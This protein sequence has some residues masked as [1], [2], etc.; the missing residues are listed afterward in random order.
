[1]CN[2]THCKYIGSYNYSY[3]CYHIF[4]VLSSVAQKFSVR[5][6]K[7][8]TLYSFCILL[9]RKELRW[10]Q[11]KGRSI[12]KIVKT[13]VSKFASNLCDFDLRALVTQPMLQRR[14]NRMELRSMDS[15]IQILCRFQKCKKKVPTT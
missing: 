9:L 10:S 14:P 12:C 2:G 11:L 3:T 6:D 15:Y 5:L 7:I 1:M 8:L 13:L 4:I